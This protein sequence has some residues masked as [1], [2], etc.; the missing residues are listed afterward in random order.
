M[1]LQATRN[2]EK[3]TD[4]LV[5]NQRIETRNLQLF[6]AGTRSKKSQVRM[7]DLALI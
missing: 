7:E 2:D 6:R 1:A 4:G 3:A 5:F